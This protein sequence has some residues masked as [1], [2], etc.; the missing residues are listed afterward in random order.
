MASESS[1]VVSPRAVPRDEVLVK[2]RGFSMDKIQND[3]QLLKLLE[4]G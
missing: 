4:K 2:S 1:K 3:T